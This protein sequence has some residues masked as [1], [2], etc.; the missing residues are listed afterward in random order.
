LGIS[1]GFFLILGL[2]LASEILR[3]NSVQLIGHHGLEY[4][5]FAVAAVFL[6]LTLAATLLVF[7][8]DVITS[9]F[10][11]LKRIPVRAWQRWL[12]RHQD[13]FHD[14]DRNLSAVSQL[15][16]RQMPLSVALYFSGWFCASL[17]HYLI[18]TLLGG[19]A[20]SS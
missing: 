14:V 1:H 15:P 11:S 7:R 6:L 12:G 13:Q 9:L 2:G 17:E 18:L 8:G 10:G 4:I 16:S 3:E 5:G 19:R 20:S